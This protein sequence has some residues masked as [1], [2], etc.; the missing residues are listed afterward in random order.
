MTLTI[1]FVITY[2]FGV[3]PSKCGFPDGSM[4]KN[5][6]ANVADVGSIPGSGRSPGEGNGNPLQYYYLGNPMDRGA[7]RAIVH[8]V[9]KESDMTYQLNILPNDIAGLL[10][11]TI[12]A[13]VYDTVV[14]TFKN[15]AS[16]PVSLHAIGVSYW[17]SSEGESNALLWFSHT[18]DRRV[19]SIRLYS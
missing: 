14:I 4:V 7:W 8:G 15:M 13:E 12:Q 6:P 9:A 16:H 1:I 17:K 18:M 11:P 5:Q 10:G 3:L 2:F 19:L